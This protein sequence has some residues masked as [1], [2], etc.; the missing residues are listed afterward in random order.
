LQ[1]LAANVSSRLKVDCR[2]ECEPPVFIQENAM[3]IHL[4]RIAQEA[5]NN[6][7]KHSKAGSILV[8]LSATAD[9]VELSVTDDG[10][11]IPLGP[12]QKDG[13]GLHIMHYRARM[14]G[15]TLSIVRGEKGGTVVS[16]VAPQ[17]SA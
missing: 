14:I 11:G 3:A 5:V 7:V 17:S 4:Y 6:A 13:M 2:T 9:R 16:C 8:R 12:A 15:G 10:V 1:Q